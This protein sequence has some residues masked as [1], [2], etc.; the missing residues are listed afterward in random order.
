MSEQYPYRT[1]TTASPGDDTEIA[2]LYGQL[3]ELAQQR[4]EA[5]DEAA[6]LKD[7]LR[8]AKVKID[9]LEV[10]V[11]PRG[12]GSEYMERKMV[13]LK[14]ANHTAK[15]AAS[16]MSRKL[17]EEASRKDREAQAA[18]RRMKNDMEELKEKLGGVRMASD[19]FQR[20]AEAS[21]AKPEQEKKHALGSRGST[22]AAWGIVKKRGLED[23]VDLPSRP[24]KNP[25]LK[26]G[27]HG[28]SGLE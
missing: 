17:E 6:E 13:R 18:I 11:D 28:S 27:T 2:C 21:S 1:G 19:A 12:Y 15:K 10:R 5:E 23:F 9:G 22:V 7:K 24:S 20:Q 14:S 3:N 26:T 4:D 16:R 25:K 8:A